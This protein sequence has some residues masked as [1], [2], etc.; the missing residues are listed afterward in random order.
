MRVLFGM[1]DLPVAFVIAANAEPIGLAIKHRYGLESDTSD[2]EARRILEKF[3]DSYED[4]SATEPLGQLIQEMWKKEN[5][6]WIIQ[7]DEANI[8]PEF[9][10]DVVKN[11]S[12]F[13]AIRTSISL[14]SNIRV[15]HKSYEHV[16]NNTEVNRHLLW[17]LWLLEIA[18]QIDPRFRR[19]LRTMVAQIEKCASLAYNSLHDVGYRVSQVGGLMKIEYEANEKGNTLFAIFRS[20]F[21][22]HACE[23]RERIGVSKD[24]EDVERFRAFEKLLSDPLRVDVVV[25][26]SL[27]PLEGISSF[28]ELCRKNDKPAL[29]DF[30]ESLRRLINEFGNCVAS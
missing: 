12:A 20:F 6:P 17:T 5:L 3:V 30:S 7:I 23:E 16:R 2:Y 1:R 21:W 13:D 14:F 9:N 19:D 10:E 22:E 28:E 24:S 26:L 4:L 8:K 29:P 15:L 11:A 25:L 27:L 18:H